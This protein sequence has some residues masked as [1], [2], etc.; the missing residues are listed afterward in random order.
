MNINEIRKK[1][2]SLEILS[3]EEI[4]YCLDYLNSYIRYHMEKENS[5][6]LCL[7]A[8]QSLYD[9]TFD[10]LDNYAQFSTEILGI[11]MNNFIHYSSFLR[12]NTN[13][14]LKW[15]IVDPTAIQFD[16]DKYPLGLD[17]YIDIKNNLNEKQKVLLENFK[18]KGY[19]ELTSRNLID[20]TNIFIDTLNKNGYNISKL[21]ANNKLIDFCNKFG[22]AFNDD[23]V[24]KIKNDKTL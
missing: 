12:F 11:E 8:S 2:A 20:Y 14:G 13:D 5:N 18:T 3:D 9:F 23:F 1:I 7:K 22:I 15:F 6:M 21:N 24:S 19:V 16:T 4:K 10:N 17:Y